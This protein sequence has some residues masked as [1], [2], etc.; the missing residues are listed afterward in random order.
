[1]PAL[2]AALAGRLALLSLEAIATVSFVLIKFQF[3][4][5]ALTV[6]LN[7]DPAVRAV[8]TPVFPEA[9]PGAAVSPGI[10]NCS[11]AKAPATT[12]VEGLVLAVLLPSVISLAVTVA[13]PA[14][15]KV[16]AKVLVPE[17]SEAFEGRLALPSLD[18][19]PTV[20][21]ALLARFQFASTA[22]TVTL[23][24]LPAA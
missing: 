3:A 23:K 21:A 1:M 2:N 7:A 11:L 6:T 24:A 4:S 14:V 18:V 20:S 16:T 13:L 15:L 5:T 19:I 17:T 22:L 10:N 8:G 12:V 9:L